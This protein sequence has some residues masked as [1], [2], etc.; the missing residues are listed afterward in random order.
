MIT[1]RNYL[2]SLFI[3]L[4]SLV[5]NCM[6]N[7]NNQ[8][9]KPKFILYVEAIADRGSAEI[10]IN[11]IP[12][13]VV[14][15]ESGLYSRMIEDYLLPKE[16]IL[17]IHS[18]NK[19]SI[20]K[21]RIAAYKEGEFVDGKTGRTFIHTHLSPEKSN[22]S[23]GGELAT[24]RKR[25]SWLDNPTL[26]T[27]RDKQDAL[28]AA[29]AIYQDLV[30]ANVAA[31]ISTLDPWLT[32][33]GSTYSQVT[34]KQRVDDLTKR[35]ERLKSTDLWSFDS[36]DSIKIKLIPAANGRLYDLR[37]DDGTP[38][39]RTNQSTNKQW[40]AVGNLIGNENGSWKIYR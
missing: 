2:K 9:P 31:L 19:N 6:A 24:D 10:R 34:K 1:S 32:E 36:F 7:E 16:N 8:T 17:S 28:E 22:N 27:E 15:A 14:T 39:L 3:I 11:D 40:F 13:G 29:K 25:W 20:A 23:A 33:V 26:N 5:G 37:R 18:E 38:L 12:I 4:I 35:V 30:K 21:A